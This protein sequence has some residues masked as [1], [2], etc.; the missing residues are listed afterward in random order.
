MRSPSVGSTSKASE[1]VHTRLLST[2]TAMKEALARWEDKFAG[3]EPSEPLSDRYGLPIRPH[4][5]RRSFRV[6]LGSDAVI[7]L[8]GLATG[9]SGPLAVTVR[10]IWRVLFTLSGG[11]TDHL[12]EVPTLVDSP[13]LQRCDSTRRSTPDN[14]NRTRHLIRTEPAN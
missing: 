10:I 11:V 2:T 3:A 6:G 13:D 5:E 8:T 9:P 4:G 12:F 7:R 14:S 1:V